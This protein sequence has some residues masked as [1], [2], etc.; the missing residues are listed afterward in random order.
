MPP[1]KGGLGLRPFFGMA[2][3]HVYDKCSGP[4]PQRFALIQKRGPDRHALGK[5]ARA[6]SSITR[7]W[8]RKIM[9]L[10]GNIREVCFILRFVSNY[11]GRGRIVDIPKEDFRRVMN[12]FGGV[13]V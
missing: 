7:L 10:C 6:A 4:C 5:V 13:V 1:Y 8:R 3:G 11:F 9:K 12:Y 2:Q